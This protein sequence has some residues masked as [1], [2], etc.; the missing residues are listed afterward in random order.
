MLHNSD[1]MF[2]TEDVNAIIA[3][4]AF[5]YLFLGE[6]PT[7]ACISVHDPV[8]FATEVSQELIDQVIGTRV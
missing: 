6:M 2:W 8:H 4:P 5:F 3:M 7:K 1:T